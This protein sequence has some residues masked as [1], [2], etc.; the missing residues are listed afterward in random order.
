MKT[1]N[2]K[3]FP[4][5]LVAILVTLLFLGIFI[6]I[7][8]N[9]FLKEGRNQ[10]VETALQEPEIDAEE[11]RRGFGAT[12][13]DLIGIFD[14]QLQADSL[15]AS[16]DTSKVEERDEVPVARNRGTQNNV[17]P[18]PEAAPVTALSSTIEKDIARQPAAAPNPAPKPQ[19]KSESEF[20]DVTF[21]FHIVR[22][23]ESPVSAPAEPSRTESLDESIVLTEARIYGPHTLR[24]MEPVTLRS[25]E[26]IQLNSREF[27]PEGTLL[28]GVSRVTPHRMEITI[29]RAMTR[30]G[31][32]PVEL[33][34]HDNDF[35]RGIFIR[36]HYIDLEPESNM[37]E[38]SNEIGEAAFGRDNQL[39]NSIT[40]GAAR[41][42][43]RDVQRMKRAS[44][45][46]PDGY[47]VYILNNAQNRQ[48]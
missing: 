47:V 18:Q 42:A 26:R 39:V 13:G 48:R 22:E 23:Q 2:K 17:T 24:H 7:R 28:F 21:N 45:M 33:I 15:A 37:D 6:T 3:K 30:N 32:F 35:Q 20:R 14:K 11:R 40:R 4:V 43:Q 10:S 9:N 16:I 41:S 8:I 12:Q 19:P 25:T 34:V 46:V 27:L 38:V 1:N 36:D 31:N 5:V 44:L 29:T